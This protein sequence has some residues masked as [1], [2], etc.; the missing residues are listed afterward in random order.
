M[1]TSH[2]RMLLNDNLVHWQQQHIK[3]RE[4]DRLA[5]GTLTRRMA[6]TQTL[7]K[8]AQ[9]RSGSCGDYIDEPSPI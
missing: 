1:I 5:P 8:A 2:N 7:Y 9:L 3:M 6:P 4:N